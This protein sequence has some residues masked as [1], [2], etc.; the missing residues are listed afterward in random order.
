MKS[1]IKRA[2]LIMGLAV[3]VSAVSPQARGATLPEFSDFSF[4]G[5]TTTGLDGNLRLVFD[6]YSSVTFTP[7]FFATTGFLGQNI[8]VVGPTGNFIAAGAAGLPSTITSSYVQ[9][10]ADGNT[11]VLFTFGND[12]IGFWTYNR[13]GAVIASALYGPF[14]GTS[15]YF[16]KRQEATGKFLVVWT[17]GPSASPSFSAWTLNEFGG[18]DTAAGPYG[19]FADTSFNGV[20]LLPNGT[21]QWLWATLVSGRITTAIWSVAQGGHFLSSVVYGPF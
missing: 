17:S 13:S 14:T 5:A 3:A 16:V 8:W 21:Q 15:V 11:S 20:N 9:G 1:L 4:S 10:Q 7:P 2:W 6:V 12:S 19:P 18:V